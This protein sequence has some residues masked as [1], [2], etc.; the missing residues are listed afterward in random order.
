LW[1]KPSSTDLSTL[2]IKNVLT[3]VHVCPS[4][5][6][7]DSTDDVDVANLAIEADPLDERICSFAGPQQSTAREATKGDLVAQIENTV[8]ARK[9]IAEDL[10]AAGWALSDHL[11]DG[12][13]A[14]AAA[15]GFWE[16]PRLMPLS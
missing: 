1:G 4:N 5:P 9:D 2:A 11:N 13:A 12:A 6:S 3:V 10:S 7:V 15:A 8:S 16:Q 14:K